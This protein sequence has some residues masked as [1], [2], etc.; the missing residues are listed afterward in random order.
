MSDLTLFTRKK[1]LFVYRCFIKTHCYS[2][3][4][5]VDRFIYNMLVD[6]KISQLH[7]MSSDVLR[8][9]EQSLLFSFYCAF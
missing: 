5:K 3:L 1:W 7:L 9:K 2:M 6:S 8:L 4:L